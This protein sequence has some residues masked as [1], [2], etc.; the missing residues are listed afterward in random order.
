VQRA[1]AAQTQ[2]GAPGDRAGSQAETGQAPEDGLECHLAFDASERSA[3]AVVGRPSK[4]K[5]SVV[6]AGDVEVIR[7]GVARRVPVGRSHNGDDRLTFYEML[8]V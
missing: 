3:E 8:A 2:V 6:G 4:R 7:I 1:E 5:V